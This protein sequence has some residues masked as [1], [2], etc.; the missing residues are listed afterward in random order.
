LVESPRYYHAGRLRIRYRLRIASLKSTVAELEQRRRLFENL[1]LD[2]QHAEWF[3]HRAWIRTIHGTTRIEGNSLNALEVED[4]L[5][6]AGSAVSRKDALEVLATQEALGFVDKVAGDRKVALD[7][8]LV[9]HI[10]TLVL[11]DIDPLLTPGAYRRGPNAVGDAQGNVIFTTPASGDVPALMRQFGIWLRRGC[12]GRPAPVAAALAHLELVGIHPF[13]DGNGRMARALARL[14]L[15]RDGYALGGLVSLD[16]YL[17]ND[18]RAYF[19]AIGA[20][21]GRSYKP[22]YDATAFVQYFIGSIV[23]AADFVL[24]RSKGLTLTLALLRRDVMS[25]RIPARSQD[26]LV[27]AWI[28]GSIRPSDYVR[29]TGR[30]SQSASRDLAAAV[31][32]GHLVATGATR[33]RRYRLG[34]RLAEVGP[35]PVI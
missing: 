29:I 35:V 4:V 17:D 1:P 32:A 7:E 16:A 18:R 19:D 11:D 2:P 24:A 33:D 26:G 6:G 10:H 22:P 15:L 21:A 23:G 20:S 28:N 27:Y 14:L 34:P 31:L 12:D 30:T 9:R 3:R 13:Y 8:R 5:V 25:G